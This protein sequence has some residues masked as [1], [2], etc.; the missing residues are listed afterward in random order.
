MSKDLKK[1]IKNLQELLFDIRQIESLVETCRG[2]QDL[3]NTSELCAVCDV[4]MMASN[5]IN[6]LNQQQTA[7]LDAMNEVLANHDQ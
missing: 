6:T 2:N 5:R 3:Q 7:K 1:D 4:L